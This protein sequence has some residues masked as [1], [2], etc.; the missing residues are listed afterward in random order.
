MEQGLCNLYLLLLLVFQHPLT[1]SFQALNL[2]F[3]QIF[4]QPFF[5]F[6]SRI[7][8]LFADTSEHI[9]FTF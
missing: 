1:L 7:P 5:S 6:S 9:R 4:P 8:A 3:L 2:P